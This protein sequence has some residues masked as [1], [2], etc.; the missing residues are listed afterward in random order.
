MGRG[1]RVGAVLGRGE[2]GEES[3]WDWTAASK[4]FEIPTSGTPRGI[5]VPEDPGDPCVIPDPECPKLEAGADLIHVLFFSATWSFRAS[6]IFSWRSA[7]TAA[8][9]GVREY[10]PEE[11]EGEGEGW[12]EREEGTNPYP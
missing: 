4:K 11:A 1:G 9:S 3:P 10:F 7:T 6:K 8:N 12:M 2:G 5:P